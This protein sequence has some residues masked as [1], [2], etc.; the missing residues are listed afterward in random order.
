LATKPKPVSE[1]W[2]REH[3]E[4]KRLDCVVIGR[5]LGK[6]PKT[7]WSWMRH[8]GIPTRPRGDATRLPKNGRATGFKLSQA[9]KDILRAARLR[10][11]RK[12]YLK[13]G[14]HWLQLPGAVHPNWRG[15]VTPERQAF[16]C[17]ADWKAA[18]VAVWHRADAKCERC[19]VNHREPGRRGSFHVH[20]IVSFQVRELRAEPTNLA[21]LCAPC[22][23]FVHGKVNVGRE[24][25]G[26]CANLRAAVQQGRQGTLFAQG[27][28]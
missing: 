19:G 3:Y 23:R 17:S 6:D 12:P 13:N 14:K 26:A 22:H 5:M 8:Y 10:D 9:H 28:A 4:A 7:I 25:L 1:A 2:L 15:G 24:F 27:G 21:L 18:C 20:H 11:G 16:Y